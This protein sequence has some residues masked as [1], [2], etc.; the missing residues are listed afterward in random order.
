MNRISLILRVQGLCLV[1]VLAGSTSPIAEAQ[2]AEA[3][4]LY[5]ERL[6]DLAARVLAGPDATAP[7]ERSPTVLIDF[8]AFG[9]Q[10]DLVL[11]RNDAL[12]HG[13]S[14]SARNAAAGIELW[15][16]RVAGLPGSWVRLSRHGG[17]FSGVISDGNDLYALEPYRRALPRLV[18]PSA[19]GAEDTIIYRLNES[20]AT[21]S[22]ILN[23][24]AYSPPR[25]TPTELA[26]A[27]KAAISPGLEVEIG[28]VADVEFVQREGSDAEAVLLSMANIVDGIFVQQLGIHIRI[29]ELVMLDAEPDPFTTADPQAL[30]VE[31]EQYKL[32]NAALTPLGLAHLFTARDLADWGPN[33]L[34]GIANFG[35]LC[36]PE[37][38]VS[39][40]QAR[41]GAPLNALIAAHEIGPNFGAP[42]DAESGSACEAT[43]TGFL[44]SPLVSSSETFSQCSIDQMS[45]EI[46]SATCLL[47]IPPNNVSLTVTSA[48][49]TVLAGDTFDVGFVLDS[50]GTED[51]LA[52]D[53]GMETMAA[54]IDRLFWPFQA[55][56]ELRCDSDFRSASCTLHWL[57]G[58]TSIPFTIQQTALQVG[59]VSFTA[60]V[61]TVNDSD[62]ADNELT[63]TIDALP[64]VKLWTI[65]FE[66]SADIVRPD[67]TV[68]VAI[69]VVNEGVVDATAA[70]LEIVHLPSHFEFVSA[71]LPDAG[72]CVQTG[73]P[74][75]WL[76]P[77]GTL[78]MG[79]PR[80]VGLRL[81][82]LDLGAPGGVIESSFLEIDLSAEE[83]DLN[84]DEWWST[85]LGV[86]AV[87][88]DATVTL[89]GPASV[90][91]DAIAEFSLVV[92]NLGPDSIQTMRL[93][94]NNEGMIIDTWDAGATA[95]RI[96]S[97]PS[98]LRCDIGL[99]APGVTHTIVI[100]GPAL[101]PGTFSAGYALSADAYGPAGIKNNGNW[102]WYVVSPPPASPPQGSG[103]GSG[104]GSRGGSGGGALDLMSV[105]LLII[106]AVSRLSSPLKGRSLTPMRRRPAPAGSAHAWSS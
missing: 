106:A 36:S 6:G 60:N 104:G 15:Q 103:G 12:L 85:E 81:R 99:T 46:A 84:R 80:V 17:G 70:Q 59:P 42:H 90:V 27:L 72:A 22:D 74:P 10:F 96:G 94:Y 79:Q 16:G 65:G 40:T 5:Y 33:Q 45:I 57:S 66:K 18:A 7:E 43:P 71:T 83:P 67:E 53:L 101:Q 38:G 8:A 75:T 48:P 41:S 56:N 30:L 14:P 39:L 76:C 69:E 102:S 31:I 26:P 50:N 35:V 29:A 63:L 105:L 44:M 55:F 34:V 100:R 20:L 98:Q 3:A 58:G 89:A 32:N 51:A 87:I 62:P 93:F 78:P 24:P 28:L 1:A 2:S 49:A 64:A 52:I 9:R 11:E 73:F 91:K 13:L 97:T 37:F 47:P 86:T 82:A 19:G 61:T 25:K 54:S 4:I 95:C 77:I 23:V 21:L 92:E 88:A 68:D